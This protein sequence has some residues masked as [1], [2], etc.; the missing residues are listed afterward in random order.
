MK[1][2]AVKIGRSRPLSASA[3]ACLQKVGHGMAQTPR[4]TLAGTAESLVVTIET[5]P[6][7]S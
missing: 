1:N 6:I 4:G 7:L 3:S 2:T 5:H